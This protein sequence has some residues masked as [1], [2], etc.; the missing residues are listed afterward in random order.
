LKQGKDTILP[1]QKQLV[2]GS[3]KPS[4]ANAGFFPKNLARVDFNASKFRALLLPP[5]KSDQQSIT[6]KWRGEM[7]GQNIVTAP[8]ISPLATVSLKAQ[9]SCPIA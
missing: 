8:R 1:Q 9:A 2:S 4:G 6:H 3:S 7:T 5:M